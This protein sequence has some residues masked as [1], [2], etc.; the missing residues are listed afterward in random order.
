MEDLFRFIRDD[1]IKKK[2]VAPKTFESYKLH[3]RES[4]RVRGKKLEQARTRGTLTKAE[5]DK[6]LNP[7]T[8][9]AKLVRF[10]KLRQKDVEYTVLMGIEDEKRS[11]QAQSLSNKV[12]MENAQMQ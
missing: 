10:S 3:W 9:E 4:I 5:K 7:V 1:H 6:L 11:N 8:E 2:S 12:Q